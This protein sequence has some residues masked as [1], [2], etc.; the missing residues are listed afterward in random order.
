M[1]IISKRKQCRLISVA[2]IRSVVVGAFSCNTNTATSVFN[3]VKP[4][5]PPHKPLLKRL[6]CVYTKHTHY[7]K[8]MSAAP[9]NPQAAEFNPQ[10]AE[11][12]PGVKGRPMGHYNNNRHNHNNHHHN[13]HHNHNHGHNAQWNGHNNSNTNHHNAKG[14]WGGMSSHSSSPAASTSSEESRRHRSH[15]YSMHGR[16][17][18]PNA[19]PYGSHPS[20]PKHPHHMHTHNGTVAPSHGNKHY[21]DANS[22][23]T[24]IA[25]RV[26]EHKV[27]VSTPWYTKGVDKALVQLSGEIQAFHLFVRL[28]PTEVAQRESALCAVRASSVNR[29]PSSSFTPYGS[30]AVGTAVSS[31]AL[32]VI[33]DNCGVL[34][35][36]YVKETFSP[37]GSIKSLMCNDENTAFVQI[38]SPTGVVVN[39]SMHKN[40]GSQA[41]VCAARACREFFE[42]HPHAVDVFDVL[43]QVMSQTGNL[44][45]N[46]GGLSAY[47]LQVMLIALVTINPMCISTPGS[48]LL[49]FCKYYGRDFPFSDYSLCP[50]RGMIPKRHTQEAISIIDPFDCEGNLAAGCTR[51]FQ[52]QVQLQH[53][54]S[55]LLRWEGSANGDR[56]GY[57][58]RTPLSGVISHQKLWSRSELIQNEL[59]QQAKAAGAAYALPECLLSEARFSPAA[60]TPSPA[61]SLASP[62]PEKQE[63]NDFLFH[64]PTTSPKGTE[65]TDPIVNMSF[66]SEDVMDLVEGLNLNMSVPESALSPS[67]ATVEPA[68]TPAQSLLELCL[69]GVPKRQQNASFGA[70]PM[71]PGLTDSPVSCSIFDMGTLT[72]TPQRDMLKASSEDSL[73]MLHEG[74]VLS[75]LGNKRMGNKQIPFTSGGALSGCWNRTGWVTS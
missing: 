46:T 62:P 17:L 11:F 59:E 50:K 70:M 18:N 2:A 55:A 15:V 41:A 21:N 48:M 56:K 29:F 38:E 52:I 60:T 39:V 16:K 68:T 36:E 42:H 69:A 23:N 57:K 40:I 67:E 32:D 45:V 73:D 22:Q 30:Y 47:A 63:E 7:N 25:G 43:R 13:N 1:T 49:Q 37:V 31:S 33:M 3:V 5:P 51:A 44:E 34:S 26:V 54:H 8:M 9:L 72:A 75:G 58:G 6:F 10:A 74:Y 24:T 28:T 64:S 12:T 27:Y 14:S 20:G 19:A 35:S 61:A 65:A 71:T 66:A 4:P 53:C